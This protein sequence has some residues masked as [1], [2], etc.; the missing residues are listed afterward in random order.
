MSL[1]RALAPL[2]LLARETRTIGIANLQRRIPARGSGDELDQLL[3]DIAAN[4]TPEVELEALG[5]LGAISPGFEGYLY[6]DLP[7]GE[8]LA[9]DLMPDAR[10]PR[11]HLLDGYA[12]MFTV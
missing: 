7:P 10:D 8:Y 12:A 11:P 5:G 3:D 9:V 1:E 2:V 4:R 6:L